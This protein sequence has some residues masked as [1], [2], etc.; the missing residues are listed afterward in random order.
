MAGTGSPV[1]LPRMSHGPTST[2]GRRRIRLTFQLSAAVHT[3]SACPSRTTHTGVATGVPSFLYE[4]ISRYLPFPSRSS[5]A[6]S[7]CGLYS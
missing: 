5:S 7:I 1:G 2:S 3:P 4:V 6:S